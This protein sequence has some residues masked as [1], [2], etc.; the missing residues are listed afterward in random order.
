MPIN[1]PEKPAPAVAALNKFELTV[2]VLTSSC[3]V[4][5]LPLAELELPESAKTADDNNGSGSGGIVSA[6]R[7][8]DITVPSTGIASRIYGT[9]NNVSSGWSFY[10]NMISLTNSPNVNDLDIQGMHEEAGFGKTANYYYN[11]VHIGGAGGV[12]N[13]YAFNRS[14]ATTVRSSDSRL[15]MHVEPCE[16]D[17]GCF[18]PLESCDR[19]DSNSGLPGVRGQMDV[20]TTACVIQYVIGFRPTKQDGD[21]LGRKPALEQRS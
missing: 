4:F 13:T 14:L 2:S 11:S 16:Y 10:N 18:E 21:L 20:A 12:S 8:Y 1:L 6:N 9:S 15:R 17:G 19:I 3:P 7:I 5:A